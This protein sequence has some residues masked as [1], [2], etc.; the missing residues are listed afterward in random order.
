MK[1]RQSTMAILG[2]TAAVVSLECLALLSLALFMFIIYSRPT[3]WY[4]KKDID[5]VNMRNNMTIFLDE[6]PVLMRVSSAVLHAVLDLLEARLLLCSIDLIEAINR[7][8]ASSSRSIGRGAGQRAP[9]ADEANNH[10]GSLLHACHCMVGLL[11]GMQW[12]NGRC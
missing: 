7:A 12:I 5:F 8:A 4:S 3:D 10:Q 1:Q 11:D 6:P 9:T 2:T